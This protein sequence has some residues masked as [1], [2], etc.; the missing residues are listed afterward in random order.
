MPF[1][2][3]RRRIYVLLF[4][5]VAVNATTA[6]A[7]AWFL[8]T[9]Q[10]NYTKA[11]ARDLASLVS[12][13]RLESTFVMQKGYI[14]Y[15]ALSGDREWLARLAERRAMFESAL[16]EASLYDGTGHARA[17]LNRIEGGY[18]RYSQDRDRVISLYVNNEKQEAAIAHWK[19]RDQFRS[20]VSLCEQYRKVH[21]AS[22]SEARHRYEGLARRVSAVGLVALPA[23]VL[24][25]LLLALVLSRQVLAPIRR[26]ALPE[27]PSP[28]DPFCRDEVDALDKKVKRL[29]EDRRQSLAKLEQSRE[30][31]IQAE[32]L[33]MVGKL[34]A[35]VAHSIRNPLTSVKMRLFSLERSLSLNPVQKE[36]FE[37]ISEE[38]G[39]L[40]TIIANFLEFARPP[41]LKMQSLS[42]SDVVDATLALFRHRLE[43]YGMKVSV[44]RGERLPPTQ[45]D[46]E[47]LKEVLANLLVNSCEAMAQGGKISI[48]E[49]VENTPEGGGF[50]S[51]EYSDNGPGISPEL[52][53]KIFEPFFSTKE[54]GSGLGLSIAKR[55]MDEH[56]GS[57]RI[58]S[59]AGS[60]ATFV[61]K[62]PLKETGTWENS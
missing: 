22:L 49:S 30:H 8:R 45:A 50:V 43:S 47:Q 14:T 6:I 18:V 10:E 15:F 40:D 54:E 16:R 25:G 39:H 41:R 7:T 9:A 44:E 32:K 46:P 51:V 23:G 35:G 17:I 27:K 19:V 12:A 11:M 13:Q 31:L 38:I 4:A 20:I 57:I 61:L 52:A 59:T 60:G 42:L 62:V 26:L 58:L 56:G 1:L 37:V 48:R 5:V 3:L 33:A 21:E 36:D 29:M 55:V 28:D 2:S 24:L 34:S 53:E